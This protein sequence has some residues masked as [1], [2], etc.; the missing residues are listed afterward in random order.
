[1]SSGVVAG[2]SGG[3]ST[4]LPLPLVTIIVTELHRLL[5]ECPPNPDDMGHSKRSYLLVLQWED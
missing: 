5:T 2:E 4:L 3:S 1:M